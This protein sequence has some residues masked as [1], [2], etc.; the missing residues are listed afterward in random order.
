[1]QQLLLVSVVSLFFC[2]YSNAQNATTGNTTGPQR[3]STPNSPTIS[4][5]KFVEVPIQFVFPF[6][7]SNFSTTYMYDNGVLGFRDPTVTGNAPRGGLGWFCCN[8]R[9]VEQDA[10]NGRDMSAYS[11]MIAPL[12]TDLIDRSVDTDGDGVV[13]SG[14]FTEGDSTSQTYYWQNLSEYGGST[15]RLNSFDLTIRDDGSYNINYGNIDI[16]SHGVAAGVAGDLSNAHNSTYDPTTHGVEH[17]YYANG[18]RSA[19][20]GALATVNNYDT[21]CAANALYDPTC[22]GYTQAYATLLYNQQCTTD[23]L[24]DAGCP[25][26]SVANYNYQCTIDATSDP[27]CPDYY[28]AMCDA[29]PLY[30]MGCT[31]YDTAYYDYQCSL[32]AQYDQGCIGYVD[33][34]SDQDYVEIFDPV[35]EEILEE[36]YTDDIYVVE[37][38]TTPVYVPQIVEEEPVFE[39]EVYDVGEYEQTLEDNIEREI[40]QLEQEEAEEV[41]LEEELIESVENEVEVSEERDV[42]FDDPTNATGQQNLED[43]IESEIAELENDAREEESEAV[44]EE[45]IQVSDSD[46]RSDRVERVEEQS[47]EREDVPDANASRRKKMR[48]LIAQKAVETTQELEEAVTL[49]QQMNIQ[50]RLLALISYVPDFKDEYTTK[51]VNQVNFYPPLPVVDHAYARWF[52]NDATFKEME[53]LQYRR[54]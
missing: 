15:L 46:P 53:D 38:N 20:S 22:P 17:Y 8:P 21:F 42:D 2:S 51:K 14:Y 33:L 41:N 54:D 10:A 48:L 25:G 5:D 34:T 1:M 44:E 23:P 9:D 26:Y 19:I 12:W 3:L 28:V 47:D 40:R 37:Q 29:D 11:F 36:E 13:D 49:E 6:F 32:D 16:R 4:D 31:G 52:V 50:R 24:Y 39:P 43:D 35:I 27:S 7:G 45:T 30:D 18:Y